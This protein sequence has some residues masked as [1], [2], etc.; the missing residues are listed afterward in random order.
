MI[1]GILEEEKG[2]YYEI[3]SW[4]KKYYINCKEYDRLIKTHFLG[5]ILGNILYIRQRKKKGTEK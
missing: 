1:T 5:T 3:S 4:G 2:S